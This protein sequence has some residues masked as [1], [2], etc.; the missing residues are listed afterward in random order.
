[1]DLCYS[2]S[3]LGEPREEVGGDDA[4]VSGTVLASVSN[5]SVLVQRNL[6]E[7]QH[8]KRQKHTFSLNNHKPLTFE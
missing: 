6:S 7:H 1:M 8:A 5:T 3:L 4:A 2:W